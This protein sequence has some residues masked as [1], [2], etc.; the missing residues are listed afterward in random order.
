M[1]PKERINLTIN[2][3]I[4]DRV[5]ISLFIHDDNNFITYL[6]PELDN[7]DH[8]NV[9][10]KI[11]EFSKEI[12][13]DLILR[14]T[15]EMTP[16]QFEW[17]PGVN[18]YEE[19]ENWKINKKI[20]KDGKNIVEDIKIKTPIGE[21]NQIFKK[22]YL[23]KNCF[24]YSN[25]EKP[26]KNKKDFEIIK[27]YHPRMNRKFP[28]KVLNYSKKLKELV[29]N[30]GIILPWGAGSPFNI[31]ADLMGQE[32]LYMLPYTDFEFYIDV[33]S[34]I[35]EYALEYDYALLNSEVDGICLSENV[36]GGFV[37]EKFYRT[38]VLPYEKKFI[39]KLQATKKIILC[40]NCGHIM[41]LLTSYIDMEI[42]FL[43][44]FSPPPIAD[45][46]LKKVK[47]VVKNK[48]VLVGNID[49]LNILQKGSKKKVEEITR[50]T[51]LEGKN[52]G[53]FILSTSDYLESNTPIE[54]IEV[55][56]ETAKKYS[57]Y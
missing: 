25:I 53:N 39:D 42:K 13:I 11:I 23:G 1:T 28:G 49:Q 45:G 54:N 48:I 3:K 46:N 17:K 19:T 44:S 10:R 4:P 20:T 6:Y 15:Y 40:H 38:F 33:Y 7:N 29:G 22:S 51:I 26:V 21:I 47:K 35:S 30:N 9:H 52:G 55:Y 41:N 36:M 5:P 56:V 24:I 37:G 16:E 12:G 8:F 43:E 18:T 31:A 2:G 14:P 50:K 27:K 57:P 32:M 34:F